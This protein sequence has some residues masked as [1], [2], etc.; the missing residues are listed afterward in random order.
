M[1]A[2]KKIQKQGDKTLAKLVKTLSRKGFLTVQEIAERS[3]LSAVNIYKRLQVLEDRGCSIEAARR[4]RKRGQ[5]GPTP[6]GFRLVENR[7]SAKILT[8]G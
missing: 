5:R 2:T 8:S 1:S 4:K 7:A 6:T 3:N